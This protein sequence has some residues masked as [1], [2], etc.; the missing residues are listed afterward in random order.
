VKDVLHALDDSASRRSFMKKGLAAA[1]TT[2][3]GTRVL[4]KGLAVFADEEQGEGSG[5]L[6]K[7]GC[8]HP[9][10]PGRSRGYRERSV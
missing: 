6:T 10:V 1:G 5:S 9:Q 7:R 4:A 3:V 2:T 8:S